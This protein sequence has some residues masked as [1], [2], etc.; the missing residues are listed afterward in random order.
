MI[1]R[2]KEDGDII[3]ELAGFIEDH[4]DMESIYRRIE[5]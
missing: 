2:S 4:V 1:F 3:G 5:G